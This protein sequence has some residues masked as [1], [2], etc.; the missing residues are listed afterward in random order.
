MLREIPAWL[1]EQWYLAYCRSPWGEDR[2]DLAAGIQVMHQV[3]MAGGQAKQP[4]EYMP[5][6][7]A[8][9]EVQSQAEMKDEFARAML[10]LDAK[11][12]K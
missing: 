2:R 9:E 3:A 4:A 12:K 11:Q 10:A 6:L 7:R 8:C 5:Y 1:F